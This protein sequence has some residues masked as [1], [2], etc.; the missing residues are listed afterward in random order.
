M[1]NVVE[2]RGLTK[3]FK[4]VAALRGFDLDVG[5]GQIVGLL[6]PNGAG[7]TTLV[8]I[9]STLL[10]PDSG[11]ARVGGFDV[12][13]DAAAARRQVGLAGQY[14]AV[15]DAL[16]GRENIE[17]IGMLSRL[18]RAEARRRA[19]EILE[20]LS[21]ADAADRLVRTY[22][23]GMRRRLDLG[24]SVV[25]K[26]RVLLFDE[27]TTGLDPRGR[28]E[29]WSYLQELVAEGASLLL[30]T[31]HMDEADHLGDEIVVID[32]GQVIAKGTPTE[33]KLQLG[34]DVLEIVVSERSALERAVSVAR[35]GGHDPQVDF[36][37]GTLTVA[38]GADSEA[39]ITVLRRLGD[40]GIRIGDFSVRRPSLD[41]V[42][43][44]LTG[45][46]ADREKPE[47]ERTGTPGKEG[48]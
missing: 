11:E 47:S 23:G 6:G 5:E 41:D 32:R 34:G 13:R 33:L 25:A 28:L 18:S 46:A 45:H 42:F 17:M 29:L 24:A 4:S 8:R 31:Q 30:T 15:D 3:S 22:S 43:L 37:V 10:R 2:A 20:R 9:L 27:P 38:I 14:V 26:P 48:S 12:V 16:T 19:G 35:D 39:A 21:L 1:T 40:A 36:D 7:K 44:A